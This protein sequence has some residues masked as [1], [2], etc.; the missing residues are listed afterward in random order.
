MSCLSNSNS[1]S[2]SKPDNGVSQK[3][4][5]GVSASSGKSSNVLKRHLDGYPTN[6][7]NPPGIYPQL[8]P[9]SNQNHPKREPPIKKT[10]V[11]FQISFGSNISYESL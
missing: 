3:F 9:N 7:G 10:K 1:S 4:A 11:V 8:Q 6:S 2:N 5:G